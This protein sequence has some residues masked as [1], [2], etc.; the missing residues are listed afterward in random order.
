MRKALGFL[1]C[2]MEILF[3]L[4]YTFMN[5]GIFAIAILV[6]V[7]ALLLT[8]VSYA[9]AREVKYKWF[10][11]IPSGTLLIISAVLFAVMRSSGGNIVGIGFAI[12]A[13]VF[14]MMSIFASTAYLVVAESLY[15]RER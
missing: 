4:T 3:F 5:R 13:M 15:D 1:L 2:T 8:I 14:I 11:F 6:V 10:Y 12:I 7:G 9:I